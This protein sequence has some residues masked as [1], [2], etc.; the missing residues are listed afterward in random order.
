MNDYQYQHEWIFTLTLLAF[1]WHQQGECLIHM[2]RRQPSTSSSTCFLS[3]QNPQTFNS[4]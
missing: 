2:H 4:R 3:T 1:S